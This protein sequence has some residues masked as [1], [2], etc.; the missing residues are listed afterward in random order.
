V[1]FGHVAFAERELDLRVAVGEARDQ[2]WDEERRERVVAGDGQV[3][4][5][6]LADVAGLVGEI[7]RTGEQFPCEGRDAASGVGE[8]ESV[9]VM[10]K[11]QLGAQLSFQVGDGKRDRG[12]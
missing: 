10:A 5:E 4:D 8:R 11:E 12:L 6:R 1:E 9:C 7:V 2:S 3:S